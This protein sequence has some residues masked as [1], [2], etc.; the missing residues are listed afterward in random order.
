MQ[1]WAMSGPS[2]TVTCNSQVTN[3]RFKNRSKVTT[4]RLPKLSTYGP[5]DTFRQM[6]PIVDN[7]TTTVS[8]SDKPQSSTTAYLSAA[9][10]KRSI[11]KKCAAFLV[12]VLKDVT[13]DSPLETKA[14]IST[15]VD[16]LLKEY[17]Q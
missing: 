8:D 16:K 3:W 2:N 4:L 11:R 17:S 9:Q 6:P 12:V 13:K 5:T 7:G 1:S 14:D 10:V 15:A